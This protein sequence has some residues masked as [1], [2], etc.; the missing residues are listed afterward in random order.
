MLKCLDL[1]RLIQIITKGNTGCVW[2]RVARSQQTFSTCDRRAIWMGSIHGSAVVSFEPG[3]TCEGGAEVQ[4][5]EAFL[6]G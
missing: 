1:T 6:R 4:F 3:L 5:G 2:W